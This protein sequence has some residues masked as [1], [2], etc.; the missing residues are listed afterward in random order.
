MAQA[1]KAKLA[2]EKR[3]GN[4]EADL[5]QAFVPNQFVE[6]VEFQG[7]ASAVVVIDEA[8]N[9]GIIDRGF[10]TVD[11]QGAPTLRR[12]ANPITYDPVAQQKAIER[13]QVYSK[14]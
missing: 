12:F 5:G 14:N 7:K 10:V 9:K 1:K 8:G 4:Q 3:S 2:H 11:A 6:F 13:F